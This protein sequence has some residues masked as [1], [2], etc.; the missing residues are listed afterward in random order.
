MANGAETAMARAAAAWATDVG[1]R[2]LGREIEIGVEVAVVA[3][4]RCQAGLTGERMETDIIVAWAISRTTAVV[5]W[6]W[7]SPVAPSRIALRTAKVASAVRSLA[8][9]LAFAVSD[10][11]DLLVVD[12]LLLPPRD[13]HLLLSLAFAHLELL[14]LDELGRDLEG[15]VLGGEEEAPELVHKDGR[16]GFEEASEADLHL[17]RVDDLPSL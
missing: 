16:L 2:C 4:L 3:V 8:T 6:T 10:L 5:G 7:R 1:A 14:L 9:L 13:G 17:L 15:R 12:D 11:V